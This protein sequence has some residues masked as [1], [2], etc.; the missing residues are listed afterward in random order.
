[1]ARAILSPAPRGNVRFLSNNH[2]QEAQRI[3]LHTSAC[4]AL[5]MAGW[6][7]NSD[8]GSIA[9]AIAKAEAATAALRRLQQIGGA[10]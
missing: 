3:A 2:L 6:N 8:V 1:M 5:A 10:A 9:E 4:N 7:L